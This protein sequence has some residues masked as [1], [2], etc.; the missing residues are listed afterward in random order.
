MSSGARRASLNI[1][2]PARADGIRADALALTMMTAALA[3]YHWAPN[4]GIA[5]VATV[6]LLFLI[7]R[8]LDLGLTLVLLCSPFF[9]FPKI[10]D[11]GLVGTLAGRSAALE[12]S[13]AE[14]LLLLCAGAWL[15]RRWRR[16][17]DA[18]AGTTVPAPLGWIGCLPPAVLILAAAISLIFTEN[19]WV[20]FREFRLVVV[21]PALYYL[22]LVRTV[23]SPQEVMRLLVALTALGAAVGT[24]ALY[25]YFFVGVVERTGGVERILAV[26]HSPNALALFLGRV[27]PVAFVLLWATLAAGEKGGRR[28]WLTRTLA[29]A[30]IAAMAGAFYFT[31]SRG[32]FL[33]MGAGV[34][35]ALLFLNRRAGLAAAGLGVAAVIALLLAVP[36]ER[37]LSATPVLQRT[38]VWEAA[39]RMAFDNPI[40]GI[41]MDNF[42]YRYPRYMLAQAALEPNISHPH[43]LVL[44]HWLSLGAIGVGVGVGLQLVF[45]RWFAAAIAAKVLYVRIAAVALAAG[46]VDFLVHGLIDNSYFLIDLAFLFWLSFGLMA[47]LSRVQTPV[48]EAKP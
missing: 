11:A 14:Y 8:R 38:Y 42:L 35:F 7:W 36:S 43:N 46:M 2:P 13:L 15:I 47:V 21:E 28:R 48:F 24:Y 45:W 40:T 33:G 30:A 4:I 5:G 17:D 12:V 41:G 10:L 29:A 23:R 3:A 18:T 37:L 20:A 9:R 26:Y 44:D 22:L 27:L 31:Y 19:R 16:P 34:L 32:A 6:A 39:L 25:H 1:N